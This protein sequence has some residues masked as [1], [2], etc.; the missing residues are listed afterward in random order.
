MPDQLI[1]RPATCDLRPATCDLRPAA[2]RYRLPMA[3]GRRLTDEAPALSRAEPLPGSSVG[4][5]GPS[6]QQQRERFLTQFAAENARLL[7]RLGGWA[8]TDGLVPT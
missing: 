2:E 5:H 3:E 7:E 6:W 1:V 4:A 8:P